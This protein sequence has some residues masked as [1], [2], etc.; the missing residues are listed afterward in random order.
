MK[1]L[2]ELIAA[3]DNKAYKKAKAEEL[4]HREVQALEEIAKVLRENQKLEK[5]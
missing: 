4:R 5:K 1:W 3:Q 2:D